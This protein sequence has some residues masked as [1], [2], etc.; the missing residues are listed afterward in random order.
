M[1][2]IAGLLARRIICYACKNSSMKIG[3]RLGFMRFGSRIDLILPQEISLKIKKSLF[4][5]NKFDLT[6]DSNSFQNYYDAK[7]YV[8]KNIK[9]LNFSKKNFFFTVVDGKLNSINSANF[10]YYQY[11]LTFIENIKIN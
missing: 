1:I 11:L 6:D 5:Y 4:N 9:L 2:Q 7:K 10:F 8:R 3:D